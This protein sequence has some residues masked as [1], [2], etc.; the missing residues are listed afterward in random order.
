M[1]WIELAPGQ[2]EILKDIFTSCPGLHGCIAAVL[3]GGMGTAF[4]D[5][6]DQPTTSYMQ[7]G[8]FQIFAGEII[9][10]DFEGKFAGIIVVPKGEWEEFLRQT[11][12]DRLRSFQRVAFAAGQWDRSYLQTQAQTLPDGF[13]ISRIDD[14]DIAQYAE[15]DGG[16]VGNF[17]NHAAFLQ[18]GIGFCVKHDGQIVAGCSSYMISGD[19]LEIE[20]NTHGDFRRRGLATAVAA[21]M[22]DYC[23]ADGIE[24]CWDAANEWSVG[25]AEKL[26]FIHPRRIMPTGS[27]LSRSSD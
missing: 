5:N 3:D 24:P 2:R 9:R 10:G 1:E 14:A 4:V 21:T 27:S 19:K 15:L 6:S 23:L 16:F 12:G 20:I 26:G 11:I 18:A 13:A 22:I 8:D 7:A 17:P 25:L